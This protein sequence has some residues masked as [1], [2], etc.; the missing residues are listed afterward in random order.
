MENLE[1]CTVTITGAL[2]TDLDG[3]ADAMEHDHGSGFTTQPDLPPVVASH[4]PAAGVAGVA[5]Q[6]TLRVD[7]ANR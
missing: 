7:S 1:S 3:D 4:V 6:A 5:P 2:V